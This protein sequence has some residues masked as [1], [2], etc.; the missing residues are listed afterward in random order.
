MTCFETASVITAG[1]STVIL[2]VTAVFIILYWKETQKM[3]DQMIEQIKLSKKQVKA[4]VM[5]V[6]DMVIETV[7]PNPDIPFPMQ[8]C[9]DL[10]V[11]NKGE[12]PAFNVSIQ[13]IPSDTPG[14]KE[15]V[16]SAPA[17]QIECFHKSFS[18]IGK[19]EE[20]FIHREHSESFRAFAL[21]VVFF[22]VLKDRY[23]S[24]FSGDRNGIILKKWDILRL[25]E[26]NKS[27]WDAP[28][29]QETTL[30]SR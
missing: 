6:L 23:I 16:R 14:Q 30:A 13:R 25:E 8:S 21:N 5:P 1:I 7:K 12:G 19:N 27:P 10:V 17:G 28:D 20:V 4:S 22:D 18:I 11:K 29:R 9:Y 24:E 3:K 2:A 15:A 26:E